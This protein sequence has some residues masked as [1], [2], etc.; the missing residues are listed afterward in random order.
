MTIESGMVATGETILAVH[1]NKLRNDVL[2]NHDHSAGQGGTVDHADL[3]ETGDMP[4]MGHCHED[5]DVHLN[6]GGPGPNDIDNPGGAYGV[7]GLASAARVAGCLGSNQLVMQCGSGS[8]GTAVTFPVTFSSLLNVQIQVKGAMT[9]DG[10]YPAESYL[11]AYSTTG[12]TA[13]FQGGSFGGS[14]F[15]WLAIGTK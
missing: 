14:G 2:S 5:I 3:T 1:L 9:G 13:Q 12:F 10:H 6:G 11:S 4:G 7:H 15:F 8:F